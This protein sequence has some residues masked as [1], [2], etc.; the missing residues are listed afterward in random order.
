MRKNLIYWLNYFFGP[1]RFTMFFFR[2]GKRSNPSLTSLRGYRIYVG[3]NEKSIHG[4]IRSPSVYVSRDA[5]K[6]TAL[7]LALANFEAK[8]TPG[9]E[10]R[11]RDH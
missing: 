11:K 10:E 2:S 4:V 1:S 3:A 8:H 7:L 6:F 5:R 9:A